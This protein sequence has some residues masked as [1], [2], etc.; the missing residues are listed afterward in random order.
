M[1]QSYSKASQTVRNGKE[2]DNSV[3]REELQPRGACLENIQT[4]KHCSPSTAISRRIYRQES[5]IM[6][7]VSKTLGTYTKNNCANY[8][9]VEGCLLTQRVDFSTEPPT[10]TPGPC[11]V[12]DGKPCQYFGTALL[13]ARHCPEKIRLH[14]GA[15]D[16]TARIRPARFCPACELA[17]LL[18]RQR[19]CQKCRRKKTRERVRRHR[20][21]TA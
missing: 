4:S 13:P 9:L 19:I 18:P 5:R 21:K 3:Q 1:G 2:Y 7:I 16:K 15:I 8:T 14:Y 6:K 10:A 17:E 11:L 12:A 20:Q